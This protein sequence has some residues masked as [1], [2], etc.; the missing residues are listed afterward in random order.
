ME[1]GR[2]ATRTVTWTGGTERATVVDG[3]TWTVLPGTGYEVRALTVQP[4]ALRWRP[5]AGITGPYPL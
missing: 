3:Y 4:L 1:G 2:R 5:R